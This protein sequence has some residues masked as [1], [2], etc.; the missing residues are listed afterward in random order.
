MD[1]RKLLFG[2]CKP[3]PEKAIYQPKYRRAIISIDCSPRVQLMFHV[4][5]AV[6]VQSKAIRKPLNRW[7]LEGWLKVS[8]VLYRLRCSTLIPI[9]TSP[10]RIKGTT[11]PIRRA[12]KRRV[13]F[14][15]RRNPILRF[16]GRP[17]SYW[18]ESLAK[19]DAESLSAAGF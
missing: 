13:R 5:T 1:F 19:E 3:H 18:F 12:G 8:Y 7:M 11:L 14:Y 9:R 2:N 4:D 10:I 16:R 6:C 15:D 17:L